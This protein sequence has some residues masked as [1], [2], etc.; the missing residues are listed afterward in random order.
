[1]MDRKNLLGNNLLFRLYRCGSTLAYT[2]GFKVRFYVWAEPVVNVSFGLGSGDVSGSKIADTL[3]WNNL[4]GGIW[5]RRDGA[6][7]N[8]DFN[9]GD[10]W[11][12]SEWNE[13]IIC[14]DRRSLTG[15]V[16]GGAAT[17]LLTFGGTD[18]VVDTLRF[19]SGNSESSYFLDDLSAVIN[20]AP[21]PPLPVLFNDGFENAASGE[22]PGEPK[23]GTI[24]PSESVFVQ[25]GPY[26]EG[27]EVG[28]EAAYGGN[29][30][31]VM[32]RVNFGSNN[33]L[34]RVADGG[35]SLDDSSK[36]K[37][38]FSLWADPVRA[39]SFGLGNGPVAGSDASN[40]LIWNNLNG[41]IWERFT[42]AGWNNDFDISGDWLVGAWNDIVICWNG[43]TLTGS[44][45]GGPP[46]ELVMI[47]GTDL[48]IDT[49]RFR[50]GNGTSAY[51]L[52]YV[53]IRAEA[54]E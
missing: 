44:V 2:N 12:A 24:E 8:E 1:V 14:W 30:Y 22:L 13:I 3:A 7:W 6:T 49:L 26:A 5:Q 11:L 38:R 10:D 32:D 20:G 19:R 35:V 18:L 50:S 48:V 23:T 15:S 52:D 33:L 25:A 17:E 43:E 37:V 28:P 21:F 4:T 42:A 39:V 53:L 9:I 45:N 41:G 34:L 46:T 54:R 29:N 40:T 27:D 36:F 51:Y 31:L 47:G 16:N